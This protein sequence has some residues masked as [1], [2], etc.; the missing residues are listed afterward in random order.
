MIDI[1]TSGRDLKRLYAVVAVVV[2]LLALCRLASYLYREFFGMCK[3]RKP[4]TG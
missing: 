3:G 1:V 4:I 2:A